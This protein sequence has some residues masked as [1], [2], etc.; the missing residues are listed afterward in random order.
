MHVHTC[1]ERER[2]AE[3]GREKNMNFKR[4]TE[5]IELVQLLF[6]KKRD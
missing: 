5:L 2:G 1:V 3:G 6:K 4:I